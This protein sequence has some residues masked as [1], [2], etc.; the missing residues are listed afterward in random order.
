MDPVSNKGIL[1]CLLAMKISFY[2]TNHNVLLNPQMAKMD[3]EAAQ[4][5][6]Q[7]YRCSYAGTTWMGYPRL[8]KQFYALI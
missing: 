6:D 2:G 7:T 3:A 4:W 1:N 5:R 8:S